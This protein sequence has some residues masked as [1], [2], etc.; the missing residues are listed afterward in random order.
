[1]KNHAAVAL[2]LPLMTLTV[3]SGFCPPAAAQAA[4]PAAGSP[5][6]QKVTS[7]TIPLRFCPPSAVVK[8]VVWP[9]AAMAGH[10]ASI[11]RPRSLVPAGVSA[12]TPDDVQKTLTVR[13]TPAGIAELRKIVRLLDVEPR[14]L[15]LE[16]RVLRSRD[17]APAADRP[18]DEEHAMN[19]AMMV[20]GGM[21]QTTNNRPVEIDVLG[22]GQGFRIELV[23]HV[24]GDDSVSLLARVAMD[25]AD[26]AGNTS[27]RRTETYR[28]GGKGRP[29]LF[30]APASA[31]PQAGSYLVEVRPTLL[32]RQTAQA[33]KTIS[34][35]ADG[36]Q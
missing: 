5:A 26:A 30:R 7:A 23:P 20:T 6:K 31:Q 16:V 32:D 33:A 34:A 36:S 4:S 2:L 15:R 11:S 13:G 28:R 18:L 35:N 29:M 19:G 14:A 21:A 3:W 1:M 25:S 10:P 8:A 24:N 17:P 9:D 27:T 12:L 22:D